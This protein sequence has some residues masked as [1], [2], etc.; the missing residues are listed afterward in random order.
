MRAA[1]AA[2]GEWSVALASDDVRDAALALTVPR[3]CRERA[4]WA[5]LVGLGAQASSSLGI[6]FGVAPPAIA[7]ALGVVAAL[8]SLALVRDPTHTATEVT[9][10]R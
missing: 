4:K 6:A 7:P 8:V 3:A 9:A 10:R 1:G 2:P 5:V